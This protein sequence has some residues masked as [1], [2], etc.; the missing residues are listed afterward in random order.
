MVRASVEAERAGVPSVSVLAT[1][2][3]GQAA[4]VARGLGVEAL[5]YVEY[6]GVIATDSPETFRGKVLALADELT[7][8]F[9]QPLGL[10]GEEAEPAPRDV[11]FHGTLDAVQERFDSLLWTDGLPIVP[12]TVERVEAFLRHTRRDPDE[13]LGTLAP[14]N[15]LA[16]VWSVAVNGVMAGCRPEY[17][18]VL[19]AAVEAIADPE[20]RIEDAGST[21]GWE[22]LV[23]IGGPV[24]ERLGFA[25]GAGVLRVGNRANTSVGRFLRLY[26]RNVAGLRTPPGGGDKAAFGATFNSAIAENEPAAREIGWPTFAM[27]RGFAPDES[28]VTVQSVVSTSPPIYTIGDRAEDLLGMLADVFG[29]EN[30]YW[31]FNAAIFGRWCPLLAMSPATASVIAR[32]GMSKDDVRE[33]LYERSKIP[34]RRLEAYARRASTYDFDLPALAAAGSAPAAYVESADPDRLVPVFSKPEWIGLMLAG[35]PEKNQSRGF[36]NNHEQGAPVSRRVDLA[37]G[38]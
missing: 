16:T 26:M 8:A 12:P 21:P 10:A 25:S 38:S 36:V 24:I 19:V 31:S 3:K 20:F 29:M 37:A 11:V 35:D 9:L 22:P 27:D 23:V 18:P 15:R 13:P 5:P 7:G 33:F 1:A 34:A 6:P 14:D 17:M 2:F 4:A 28:V 32:D 30:E